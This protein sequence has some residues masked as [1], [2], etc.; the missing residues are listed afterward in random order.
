MPKETNK[1]T[2]EESKNE[3]AKMAKKKDGKGFISASLSFLV[4]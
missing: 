4:W 2:T 3:T 1:E